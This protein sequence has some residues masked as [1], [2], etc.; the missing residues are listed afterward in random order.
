LHSRGGRE[1]TGAGVGRKGGKVAKGPKG[2]SGVQRGGKVF[3]SKKME[4]GVG[5]WKKV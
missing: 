1:R 4:K 3:V 2:G 5:R